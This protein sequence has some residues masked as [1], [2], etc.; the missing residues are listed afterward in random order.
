MPRLFSFFTG[1]GRESSLKSR[2][3]NAILAAIA[4][5]E[6]GS[7]LKISVKPDGGLLLEAIA[8][9]VA[10]DIVPPVPDDDPGC[11]V[12]H[13][14]IYPGSTQRHYYWT[15]CHKAGM[16]TASWLGFRIAPDGSDVELVALSDALFAPAGHSHE[17]D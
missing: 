14:Q 13:A 7:G 16:D 2:D 3:V 12:L 17:G 10:E 15:K 8:K 4:N 9:P 5:M 1:Y 6:V 11:Y